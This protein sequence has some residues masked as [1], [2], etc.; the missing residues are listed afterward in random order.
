[1]TFTVAQRVKGILVSSGHN[2]QDHISHEIA[3]GTTERAIAERGRTETGRRSTFGY[4]MAK[5][6]GEYFTSTPD[7][8]EALVAYSGSVHRE[9]ERLRLYRLAIENCS[10]QVTEEDDPD[11]PGRTLLRV[12]RG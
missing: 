6:A 7:G 12:A 3:F 4:T 2:T 11:R 9:G 5:F 1:M 10:F 8:E